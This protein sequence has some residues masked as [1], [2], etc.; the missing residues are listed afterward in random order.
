[1][2]ILKKILY[3]SLILNIIF[4]IYILWKVYYKYY[5]KPSILEETNYIKSGKIK[6]AFGKDE[7]FRKMPNDTNEI[8]FLGNS[9]TDNFELVE[10]FKDIRV[11]NRG[12]N[13]DI[14]RGVINRLHEITEG[15]PLKVFIEIGINDLL[16]GLPVDTVKRNY[17][18]IID[19]IH[20]DSP[21]TK[22]YIQSLLPT[23]KKILKTK[24]SVIENVKSVNSC[25]QNLA[26]E[27]NVRYIN[28]F[29]SFVLQDR[30]NKKYDC[31]DSLH[32]S[33]DGYLHWRNMV[34]KYVKE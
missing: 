26:K 2:K 21:E 17:T 19:F 6:Y 24:I 30:L 9:L 4:G 16:I 15:R 28:L 32:L 23:N 7:I 25:L 13:R 27:K 34:E 20:N 33:G 12:I 10:L 5:K 3:V 14:T 1:M 29:D 22:I 11:K 18:E 8:I 31:G